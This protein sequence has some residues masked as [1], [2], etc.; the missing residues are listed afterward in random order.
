MIRRR[1]TKYYNATYKETD[2]VRISRLPFTNYLL[3]SYITIRSERLPSSQWR[4]KR[5]GTTR[6]RV[7]PQ[8]HI[9][10]SLTMKGGDR[11][12]DPN[13]VTQFTRLL[14]VL[15]NSYTRNVSK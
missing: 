11:S 8:S 14:Y 4:S 15:I 3:P 1:K 7:P 13:M 9:S 5:D 2:I 10:N 12:P 6:C